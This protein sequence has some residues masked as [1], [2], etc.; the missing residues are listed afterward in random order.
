MVTEGEI[1]N[2]AGT[3]VHYNPAVVPNAGTEYKYVQLRW[4]EPVR[5]KVRLSVRVDN[6][7]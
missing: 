7:V 5:G 2:G 6:P 4:P 3:A 1:L